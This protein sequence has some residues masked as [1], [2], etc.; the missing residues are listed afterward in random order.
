MFCNQNPVLKFYISSWMCV[1]MWKLNGMTSQ[2]L[3]LVTY[4]LLILGVTVIISI[5]LIKV[6]RTTCFTGFRTVLYKYN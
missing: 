3:T 1:L 5:K 4:S 6:T 2:L